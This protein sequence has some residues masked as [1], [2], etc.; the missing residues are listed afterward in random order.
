MFIRPYDIMNLVTLPG[1]SYKH[2][3]NTKF[4]ETSI[5]LFA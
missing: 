3:E 5:A 4:V 1:Y 2:F